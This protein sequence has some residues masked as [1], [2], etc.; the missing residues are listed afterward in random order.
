MK[1]E[2]VLL[3]KHYDGE[4]QKQSLEFNEMRYFIRISILIFLDLQQ[5]K[6]KT[7]FFTYSIFQRKCY[8]TQFT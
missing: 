5:M 7:L 1:F 3:W 4:S 8:N 6:M 2:F